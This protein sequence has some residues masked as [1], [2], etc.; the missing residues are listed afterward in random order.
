MNDRS[1]ATQLSH[2]QP[3]SLPWCLHHSWVSWLLSRV[4]DLQGGATGSPESVVIVY[5][6]ADE[7]WGVLCSR[8]MVSGLGEDLST[9][10][11][12]TIPSALSPET[13]T[14]VSLH[15]ILIPFLPPST[16]AQVS[17]FKWDF[18]G[19]PFKRAAVPL[20]DSCLSLADRILSDFHSGCYIGAPS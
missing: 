12:V 16:R 6:Q 20:E 5:P 2:W 1:K 7:R 18:V 15:R 9:W 17:D 13:Q 19:G 11:F 4:W 10:I 14:P 3:L 8:K